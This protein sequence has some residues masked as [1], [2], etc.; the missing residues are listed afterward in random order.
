MQV[1][2][3]TTV[4]G[5][6]EID[7][8]NDSSQSTAHFYWLKNLSDSTLYVSANPNPIAEKDD[9]AE[10]PAKGAVSVETDEGK[11]YVLGAGKVE[12]HRTNSK[13]CPFD[14]QSSGSGGGGT[15][16]AY[17]KT[18]SDAKYATKSDV[19]DAYTKTES[20]DKYTQKTDV[21][22]YKMGMD[23]GT[24]TT[25][26]ETVVKSV[27]TMHKVAPAL[28]AV[29]AV[30]FNNAVPAQARLN[31]NGLM[32]YIQYRGGSIPNGVINAGDIATFMYYSGSGFNTFEIL[33]VENGGNA[34]TVDGKH[35]SDFVQLADEI[36]LNN[37]RINANQHKIADINYLWSIWS[38]IEGGNLELKSPDGSRGIQFDCFDN[39]IFR[40]YTYVND[41]YFGILEMNHSTGE[42]TSNGN[43][44]SKKPYVT[45][46]FTVNASDTEQ[47]IGVP[48]TFN[49]SVVLLFHR[50]STVVD[51]R[52]IISTALSSTEYK[53]KIGIPNGSISDE[54]ST[55][56]E[57]IINRWK[58]TTST[59]EYIA[60]K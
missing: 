40:I 31:I 57:A 39:N 29:F 47:T 41:E 60:Y 35:A 4:A 54:L 17:S 8:G 24:C 59:I 19:P 58:G 21:V 55:G 56:F 33:S 18:E 48:L 38:D 45:G 28:G 12:I 7:F 46:T 32:G 51:P 37:I 34:D 1:K 23:F 15:I 3:I 13:F 53:I 16:D 36:I 11:I 27:T 10:L 6:N 52:Q 5:V 26:A 49:P 2:T 22:P 14:W 50:T 43:V 44:I 20:D 9:V 42:V 30:K 25:P